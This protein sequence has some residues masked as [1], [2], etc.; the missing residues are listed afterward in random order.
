M[1]GKCH[2]LQLHGQFHFV[3]ELGL[4]AASPPAGVVCERDGT[5]AYLLWQS[6]SVEVGLQILRDAE[7]LPDAVK[8]YPRG[9]YAYAER[10]EHSACQIGLRVAGVLGPRKPSK[11]IASTD[12]MV[13]L[14]FIVVHPRDPDALVCHP[15]GCE[16]KTIRFHYRA[17]IEFLRE[18]P[19]AEMIDIP[20][21]H[22]QRRVGG[23][24]YMT[25]K[26][27]RVHKTTGGG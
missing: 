1:E 25:R 14:G 9:T 5:G 24:D 8:R 18:S 16:V 15:N 22:L 17:L 13:P 4:P 27:K 3:P 6:T 7:V 10:N 23:P 21:P 19:L 12:E 2:R 11:R 20:L 26:R